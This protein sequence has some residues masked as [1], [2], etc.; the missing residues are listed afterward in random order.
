MSAEG[1]F[2]R[3]LRLLPA[4]FRADYGQEISQVF[5]EQRREAAAGGRMLELR[6]WARTLADLLAV[7]PREH[8]AQLRQDVAYAARG[9]RRDPAFVLAAVLTLALG[10]GANSAIFS[11]THAVLL[12]PLPYGEPHRLVGVWNRWDGTDRARLSV[13]EYL[14]YTESSGMLDIAAGTRGLG[15]VAAGAEAERVTLGILTVNGLDVLGIRLALGRG[16]RQEEER[17]GA[18]NVAVITHGFWQRRLGGAPSVLGTTLLVDGV[19]RE[20]VGVLPAGFRLPFDFTG[21]PPAEVLLPLELDRAAPRNR[22]GGHFLQAFARL[23]PGL[24]MA[25]AQTE[26]D[27]ILARLVR[28]YPDQHDQGG[29][30]LIVTPLRSDILGDARPVLLVLTAAVALVLVVAC[31]NVASLLLAR[32]QARRRELALRTALGAS[33]FRIVRQ[34]LTE[35][36]ALSLAG[37]A[38][39]L[40]VALWCQRLVVSFSPRALP[41]ASDLALDIP[42]IAFS[43]ALGIGAAL[44]FGLVPAL[45]ISRLDTSRD[46]REGARGTDRGGVRMRRLLVVGQLAMAVVLLVGAGLLVKSFDRLMRVPRGFESDRVLSVRVSLPPARYPDR[47]AIVG[48]LGRLTERLLALPGVRS[49]GASSGLPLAVSSG[50]WSFDIEGRPIVNGR[51]PGA[52]DFYVVTPGY[53]ETLG[54]R[55]VRGRLPDASDTAESSPVVFLNETAARSLFP[56]EEPV[57]RRVRFTRT[58]G[59]EQPWRTIAGVVGD[60]RQTGLERA[61]RPEAYFPATQFLHFIAGVESRASSF[62]LKTSLEPETAAAAV[63]AAVRT[64]DPEVP[65]ASVRAMSGVVAD[66]VRDRRLNLILIGAFGVL[67]LV[68]SLVGLYGLLAYGVARR[69]RELGVRMALGAT[70]RAV[71]GLVLGEGMHLVAT[72]TGLGLMLALGLGATLAPFLFD[73]APR[74]AAVYGVI[75][76]LFAAAALPACGLPALRAVRVDPLTALRTE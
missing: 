73:V 34:L 2:R 62:V 42:V 69:T 63:Q 21:D 72:G 12:R 36:L 50:D 19:S 1:W 20:I 43:S 40:L 37:A 32:G 14:D 31:A 48:Y 38:I 68:L 35:A 25:N 15:N 64:L 7:G 24:T 61:P 76:L 56:A 6:V 66:S 9:M 67:A 41:R 45:Q 16:F 18:G 60:V 13:P 54:I 17:T 71:L 65:P 57:G 5:R 47:S 59:S 30:A 74:D 53:F 39:G 4:D 11:I 46:L 44:L 49:V 8:L 51:H 55:L 23:R 10:I 22:R 26:L 29:F 58:T 70:R 3:L 33:R 27:G 28:E 75:S 52:A